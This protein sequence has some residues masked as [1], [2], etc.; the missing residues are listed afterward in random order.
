MKLSSKL[1]TP[2]DAL[3]KQ[4]LF[5]SVTELNTPQS[6]KSWFVLCKP[7]TVSYVQDTVHIAVKMKSRLIKP[8][9]ILPLGNY[10]AGIHHLRMVRER[11]GKDMHGL[12]EKDINHK[13]KQNYEAV[14]RMT[15]ES[16]FRSLN[17]IPDA[18]GT[19]AYLQ[20]LRCVIDS[21]LD[22]SLLPLARI[23]KI[24]FA[25]FFLRYWRHWIVLHPQYSLGNNFVTQNVYMCIELNAHSLIT[26][27]RTVQMLSQGE[28][29]DGS[30]ISFCPWL[31]GSVM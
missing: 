2:R 3:S 4:C 23:E 14:L 21:Y 5:S 10:V 18:K 26:F 25:L 7:T 6:W 27:L 24:W 9:I 20:V 31:L 22:K 1:S 13:D 15:S 12:R 29:D 8:S 28:K 16:V 30:G 11:F 17:Q 19:V